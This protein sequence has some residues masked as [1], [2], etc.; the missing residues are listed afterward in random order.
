[1]IASSL[2]VLQAL[3]LQGFDFSLQKWDGTALTDAH[4][5]DMSGN[6]YNGFVLLAVLAAS[7]SCYDWEMGF[8]AHVGSGA[9]ADEEVEFA[10]GSCGPE[11]EGESESEADDA[12]FG[13]DMSSEGR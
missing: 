12:L 9:V 13:S 1:M 5:L 7:F 10:E 6:A 4:A 8:A 11:D 2:P 3:A